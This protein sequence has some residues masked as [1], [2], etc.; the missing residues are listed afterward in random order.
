MIFSQFLSPNFSESKMYPALSGVITGLVLLSAGAEGHTLMQHPVPYP[1]QL[2][3]NGPVAKDGS[4]WPC[5]GEVDYDGFG[6]SNIWKRGSTEY[7][8]YVNEGDCPELENIR[9]TSVSTN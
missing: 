8:Q 6:V 1:S 5:K 3:D 9:L 7:L 2:Q 4:D